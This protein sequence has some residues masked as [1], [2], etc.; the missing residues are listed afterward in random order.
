MVKNKKSKDRNETQVK[1]SLYN[2][3]GEGLRENVMLKNYSYI[4]IGGPAKYFYEAKASKDLILAVKAAIEA[5]IKFYI[6]AGGC[7]TLINSK[8]VDGLVINVK[9]NFIKLTGQKEL[10]VDAGLML[11]DLVKR[12][13]DYSLTGLQWAAG[14]PGSVG[15][16]V[17]G[18]AGAYGGQMA[19]VVKSVEIF[20][21]KNIE[22]YNNDKIDFS[23]RNSIFKKQKDPKKVILKVNVVLSKAKDV[24]DIKREIQKVRVKRKTRIPSQPSLG[25]IFKNVYLKN[26]KLELKDPKQGMI[27]PFLKRECPKEYI[28]R[29]VIPAGFLLNL[30]D[31]KGYTVGGVKVSHKNAN[32]VINFNNADSED[33]IMMISVLKSKVRSQLGIHLKEE[34]VYMGF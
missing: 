2:I 6:L 24:E 30:L 14:I 31:L 18:N 15:G 26:N 1:E 20:N 25:C 19:D 4:E 8:G 13:T 7:N 3:I 28:S 10:A 23:Y 12:I 33:M 29:G 17:F 5:K 16:A 9:N 27:K 34:I 22:I 32:I 11:N 21:G